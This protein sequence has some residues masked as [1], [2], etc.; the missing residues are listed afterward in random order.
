M[1]LGNYINCEMKGDL[2]SSHLE[3]KFSALT[4]S[5]DCGIATR[6]VL[7]GPQDVMVHPGVLGLVQNRDGYT[8][9]EN[10][11]PTQAS[12]SASSPL[13]TWVSE[14]FQQTIPM[15]SGLCQDITQPTV[16]ISLKLVSTGLSV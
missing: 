10:L 5:S 8:H 6:V 3:H 7:V 14:A 2:R 1:N 12:P 15:I 16:D 4:V 11:W 13:L 9:Q